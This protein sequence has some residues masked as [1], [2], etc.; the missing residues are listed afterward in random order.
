VP[1]LGKLAGGQDREAGTM[2]IDL[3]AAIETT[4][5]L[6]D[7]LRRIHGIK[8]DEAGT[9]EAWRQKTKLSRDLLRLKHLSDRAGVE[10]MDAYWVYKDHVDNTD[11][12]GSADTGA[13][14]E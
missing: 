9:R 5:H 2:E 6:L 4:Q 3:S 8:P 10:V 13:T 7:Q 1:F 12:A 11:R 14:R